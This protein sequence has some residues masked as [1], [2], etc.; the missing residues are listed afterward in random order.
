MAQN[1]SQLKQLS[2]DGHQFIYNEPKAVLLIDLNSDENGF[3]GKDTDPLLAN[4]GKNTELTDALIDDVL[5][6]LEADPSLAM[7]ESKKELTSLAFIA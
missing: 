6:D 7:S 4:L 3:A 2:D 1:Y 5:G